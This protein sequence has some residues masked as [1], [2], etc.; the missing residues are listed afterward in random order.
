MSHYLYLMN[1]VGYLLCSMAHGFFNL[2]RFVKG[3]SIHLKI[4]NQLMSQDEMVGDWYLGSI[5]DNRYR[6]Q[7]KK[8]NKMARMPRK[9]K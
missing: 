7:A 1:N 8:Y 6:L 3:I 5:G 9:E 4:T 2:G